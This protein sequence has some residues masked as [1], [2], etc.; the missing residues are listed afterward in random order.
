MQYNDDCF[1]EAKDSITKNPYFEHYTEGKP[2]PPPGDFR[3]LDDSGID[4]VDDTS[5]YLVTP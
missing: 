1:G 2:S 3:L 5:D 4:L